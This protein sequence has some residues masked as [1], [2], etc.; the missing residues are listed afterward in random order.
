MAVTWSKGRWEKTALV[1]E[2]GDECL[3]KE[4]IVRQSFSVHKWASAYEYQL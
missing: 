2:H 1:H 3:N 4:G